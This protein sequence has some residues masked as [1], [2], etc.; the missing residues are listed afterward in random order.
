MLWTQT[1]M[2]VCV[3]ALGWERER[4]REKSA[5]FYQRGVPYKTAA[6][7]RGICT[8]RNIWCIFITA[9]HQRKWRGCI[10]THSLKWRFTCWHRRAY[11]HEDTHKRILNCMLLHLSV[12]HYSSVP[13]LLLLKVSTARNTLVVKHAGKEKWIFSWINKHITALT[14][15]ISEAELILRS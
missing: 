7:D 12:V 5:Q 15:I 8:E 10:C 2:Y 3:P 13:A 11:T 9:A 6:C 1:S 4:K 14:G